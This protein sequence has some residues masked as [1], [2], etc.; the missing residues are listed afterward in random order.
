MNEPGR[1]TNDDQGASR[2]VF[3]SYATADRKQ[4]LDIC[5]AIE[6]RGIQ[7]W[8]ASRN[9]WRAA[10]CNGWKPRL[11]RGSRVSAEPIPAAQCSGLDACAAEGS[12][13]TM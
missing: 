13:T 3:I 4:A 6:R 8:I 10:A 7:C 11:L 2:P 5:K 1:A 12:G 9:V